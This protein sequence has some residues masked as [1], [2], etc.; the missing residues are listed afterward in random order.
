MTE[1]EKE[2]TLFILFF[3]LALNPCGVTVC[4]FELHVVDFPWKQW[5][6]LT[7]V[8]KGS[9]RSVGLRRVAPVC[10][11]QSMS[12]IQLYTSSFGYNSLTFCLV[13][14][15][16]TVKALAVPVSFTKSYISLL[17]G[18]KNVDLFRIRPM[19]CVFPNYNDI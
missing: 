14:F 6:E 8:M 10:L 17:K 4:V 15:V 18:Q 19:P 3:F 16:G 12:L 2:L 7:I 1:K 9:L 5:L 11:R 13:D